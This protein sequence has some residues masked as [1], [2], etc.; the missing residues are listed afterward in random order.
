MKAII[1]RALVLCSVAAMLSACCC[2][3]GSSRPPHTGAF[4]N[5]GGRLVEMQEYKGNL[6]SGAT[7]G[8]PVTSN[9]KPEIVLWYPDVNVSLLAFY[10]TTRGKVP[11]NATPTNDGIVRIVPRNDLPD[12]LYCLSQGNPLLPSSYLPR[13]YLRVKGK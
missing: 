4:L 8:I 2:S 9:R 1:A 7:E 6:P 11:F 5:N 13:W 10:E 12:G 3:L